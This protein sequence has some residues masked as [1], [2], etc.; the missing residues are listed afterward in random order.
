M[1]EVL[2]PKVGRTPSVR[3]LAGRAAPL[4]IQALVDVIQSQKATHSEKIEAARLILQ[5]GAQS[6]SSVLVE[7]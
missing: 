3:P 2:I 1:S 7:G 6:K 4:A 5:T